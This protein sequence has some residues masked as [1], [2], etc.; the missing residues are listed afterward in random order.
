MENK[1]QDITFETLKGREIVSMRQRDVKHFDLGEGRRQAIVFASPVHYK[2]E[3][4][5]AWEEIDN[6]LSDTNGKAVY[7]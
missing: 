4:T 2:N 7:T 1:V 3:K 6:R 5:G